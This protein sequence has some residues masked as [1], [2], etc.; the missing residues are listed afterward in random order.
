LKKLFSEFNIKN[1]K[2]KN[3][4][5][6]PPMVVGFSNDGY[7]E[8][9]NVERYKKLAQG[10]AGLIIQ[11]ATCINPDGKLSEKQLG[12]WKDDHI[13]GL[14]EIVNVVHKEDC[15]IFL[16]IHH[17]GVVGISKNPMCPSAYEYKGLVRSATGNEMTIEDIKSIQNDY[18][19]AARRAYEVGYD[20]IELHGCHGYL[21]SQFF[22]K[23]VNKRTDEYGVN[24]EKFVI[25]ILEGIR[26]ITPE[27]FVVGIRLG[28][29]EPTIEDG[30]HYAKIL[31]KNGVD[32]LD[33][34][35]GFMNEQEMHVEEEYK[36]SKA[37]YAA[38]KIKE[39]VL[40]IP[41]FAVNGIYSCE[42]A[43]EVLNETNVDI[44]D[45]GRGFLI[46]PNWGNDA[47]D[48]KDTGKCL[49]CPKCMWFGQSK[50][51]PGKVLFERNNK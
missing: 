38:Q 50:V 12:I 30:L 25:E 17:A 48:A 45:I 6:V 2:L 27:D 49:N 18:F 5:C 20:G 19:E 3:R 46:N 23:R 10:G 51:C 32:F 35:Y 13:E 21:I 36:Y 22:N 43:E 33:I 41:V 9:Q 39:E 28:G 24:P 11:E 31:E 16:Q 42:N 8:A 37:V 15:P 40:S 7:V 26:K 29:F 14:K 47:K 34:S 1:V 44:V 4:I